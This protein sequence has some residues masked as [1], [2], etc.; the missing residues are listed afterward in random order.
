MKSLYLAETNEIDA[1]SDANYRLRDLLAGELDDECGIA[2]DEDL[3]YS[4]EE[5]EACWH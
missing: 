1:S 3:L 2:F 4:E 5:A